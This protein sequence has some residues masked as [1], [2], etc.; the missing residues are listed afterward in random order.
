MKKQLQ[1]I[2][3]FNKSIIND[4]TK[5][6][7]NYW[8]F[9]Y[10]LNKIIISIGQ[11]LD[12]TK[13]NK[14]GENI[15]ISKK[16]IIDKSATITGPCIIDDYSIVKVNAFIRENVIIG[17]NCVIGNSSEVKN[18]VLFDEA[19]IPH[20][21]YIGD[22]IL[23]YKA[24]FGAGSITSNIKSDESLVVVK[25]NKI[26]YNTNKKKLGS[27]V[28]DYVEIGCNCVLNP[29]VIIGRNSTIYPLT[30]VRGEIKENKIVKS[31]N[32]T[33]DKKGGSNCENIYRF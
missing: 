27:I 21:N 3:D 19:K 22:S 5:E 18:S 15:W 23:G 17:K 25:L 31:L 33:I 4:Y 7:D 20:F 32:E 14:I 13:Y 6:F 16:A 10:D 1:N 11:N 8:N 9:L 2:L 12:K 30:M 24:H 26:K 28:G 29:G